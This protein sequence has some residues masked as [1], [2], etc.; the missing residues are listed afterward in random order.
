MST[1]KIKRGTGSTAPASLSDGEL[2]HAQ[3]SNVL[4]IGS[5][6]TVVPLVDGVAAATTK[7]LAE[8]NETNIAAN[9]ASITDLDSGTEGAVR[10]DDTDPSAFGFV[11]AITSAAA[12][13][14][15]LVSKATVYSIVD[16]NIEDTD[17]NTGGANDTIHATSRNAVKTYVDSKVAAA[18]AGAMSYEGNFNSST[19]GTGGLKG[20]VFEVAAAET[21]LGEV[22]EAG[23][24]VTVKVDNP[25]TSAANYN[26]V[27]KNIDPT[28]FIASADKAAASGVASLDA[29]TEVVQ[30]PAGAAAAGAGSL[31]SQDGTWVTPAAVPTASDTVAGVSEL[32]TDAEAITGTATDRVMTPANFVAALDAYVLDGGTF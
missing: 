9:L 24:T 29:N 19:I 10:I 3:G 5:G 6:A 13:P 12:N 17:L 15:R 11:T 23:D 2:A 18:E 4:Y 20:Q 31:L 1:I 30:L 25:G 28:V 26:F 7:A 32:S 21:F 27:N 14:E 8:T 16:L 22:L